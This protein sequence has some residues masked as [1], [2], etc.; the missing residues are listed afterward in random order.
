MCEDPL[1]LAIEQVREIN[2]EEF[3]K[4]QPVTDPGK[5]DTTAPG[6]EVAEMYSRG[7]SAPLLVEDVGDDTD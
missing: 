3:S 7:G 5:A 6:S 4:D 1:E 2:P